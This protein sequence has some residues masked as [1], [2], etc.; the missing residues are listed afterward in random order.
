[1]AAE[2]TWIESIEKLLA[3]TKREDARLKAGVKCAGTKLR[4]HLKEVTELCKQVRKEALEFRKAIPKAEPKPKK[5]TKK[6]E[7]VA[8]PVEEPVSEPAAPAPVKAKK[9]KPESKMPWEETEP[10]P[11]V[12]RRPKKPVPA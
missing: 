3:D 9:P 5:V 6:P 2:Q 12:S 8:E 10:K 1:M 7:E 11:I 4:G